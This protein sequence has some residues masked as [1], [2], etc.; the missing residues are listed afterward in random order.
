[1]NYVTIYTQNI[2]G[3]PA[4]SVESRIPC[5]IDESRCA[6][7]NLTAKLSLPLNHIPYIRVKPI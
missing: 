4:K 6:E 5:A 2:Y 7:E 1:M 3:D